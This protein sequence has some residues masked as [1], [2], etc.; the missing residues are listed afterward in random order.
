M[1]ARPGVRAVMMTKHRQGDG[2]AAMFEPPADTAVLFTRP[3]RTFFC[4][5]REPDRIGLTLARLIADRM[6]AP[7]ATRCF[8]AEDPT[9]S[10]HDPG[11]LSR[12]YE[13]WLAAEWVAAA[14]NV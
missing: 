9:C 7:V 5:V 8:T 2:Y 13:H 11:V 12:A 3:T 4:Q 6:V 10:A 1:A 14:R